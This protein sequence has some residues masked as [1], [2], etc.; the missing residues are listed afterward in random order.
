MMSVLTESDKD[1]IVDER[2]AFEPV[3][4]LCNAVW[5]AV[6]LVCGSGSWVPM[7]CCFINHVLDDRYDLEFQE[8][9]IPLQGKQIL[10]ISRKTNWTRKK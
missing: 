4:L 7:V 5:F 3:R 1:C 2:M 8:T 9:T 10:I 6:H